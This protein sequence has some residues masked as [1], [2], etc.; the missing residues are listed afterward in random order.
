MVSS[1]RSDISLVMIHMILM[2]RMIRIKPNEKQC[3][4]INSQG[5]PPHVNGNGTA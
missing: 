3:C 4:I 5:V 1:R 2:T